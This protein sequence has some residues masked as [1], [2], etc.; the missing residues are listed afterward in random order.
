[1]FTLLD[2]G[3]LLLVGCGAKVEAPTPSG[4]GQ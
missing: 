3:L 2:R 1:M 4:E